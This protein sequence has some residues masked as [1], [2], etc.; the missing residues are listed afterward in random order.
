MGSSA[1]SRINYVPSRRPVDA[2]PQP[3]SIGRPLSS[4]MFSRPPMA[5]FSLYYYMYASGAHF[6]W[7]PQPCPT[8]GLPFNAIKHGA[9]GLC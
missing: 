2:N 9:S 4:I 5:T 3:A 6:S 1:S 8:V 7:A